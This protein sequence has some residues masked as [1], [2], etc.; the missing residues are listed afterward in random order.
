MS[1]KDLLAGAGPALELKQAL[2]RACRDYRG[3]Q[4]AVALEMGV[5]PDA[6]TKALSLRDPRPIR[7]EWIEEIVAITQDPR[8]LAALVRPAGAVAFKPVPVA[9]DREALKALGTLLKAESEFVSSLHDGA[10]DSCWEAHEVATLR[11]HANEMIG[12]ILAIVAG[13]ELAVE[14][15]HG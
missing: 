12:R 2:Y 6:L 11:F 15:A 10:A 8:L 3:G 4:N 1:R 14:V 9:A 13:A 5:D 7:V